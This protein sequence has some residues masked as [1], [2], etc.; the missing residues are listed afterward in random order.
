MKTSTIQ[1]FADSPGAIDP[2]ILEQLFDQ[3]HDI[4]FFMKDSLSRYC[5]VNP[6]SSS[7]MA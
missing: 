5:I 1:K 4:A 6:R 7:D 2:R 3:S